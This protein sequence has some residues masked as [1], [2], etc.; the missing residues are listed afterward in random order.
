MENTP[1][2]PREGQSLGAKEGPQ[3]GASPPA[4]EPL[5]LQGKTHLSR[6]LNEVPEQN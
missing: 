5:A 2:L 1:V 6:G 3:D 4:A